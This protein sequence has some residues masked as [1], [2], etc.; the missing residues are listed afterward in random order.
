MSASPQPL[1][2]Q[3]RKG[4]KKGESV[5]FDLGVVNWIELAQVATRPAPR[6]PK[7]ARFGSGS[8]PSAQLNSIR[9]LSISGA[10]LLLFFPDMPPWK[11]LVL[12]YD[13]PGG[14]LM[15]R[16]QHVLAFGFYT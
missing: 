6:H 4:N 11:C 7:K 12:E 15:T 1:E 5:S 13:R 9:R 3:G 14:K 10:P 2:A 16:V 8:G